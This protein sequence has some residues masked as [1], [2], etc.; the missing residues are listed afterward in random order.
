MWKNV[1][2]NDPNQINS[3]SGEQQAEELKTEQGPEMGEKAFCYDELMM[4]DDDEKNEFLKIV[5]AEYNM[6]NIK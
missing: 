5:N 1:G 2:A 6:Q 4:L 3:N